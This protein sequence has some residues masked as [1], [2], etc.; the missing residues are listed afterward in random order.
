M[1]FIELVILYLNN[2]RKPI[3]LCWHIQS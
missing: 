3:L 1:I 2:Y